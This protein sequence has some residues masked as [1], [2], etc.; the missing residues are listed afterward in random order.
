MHIDVQ[1]TRGETAPQIVD[2]GSGSAVT[3]SISNYG[4]KGQ[5]DCSLIGTTAFMNMGWMAALG[6]QPS[7]SNLDY[8]RLG[9][10][11]QAEGGGAR[12]HML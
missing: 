8:Q 6:C 10:Q 11:V 7:N 9:Y 1:A 3:R 12:W 5:I 4:L 2:G